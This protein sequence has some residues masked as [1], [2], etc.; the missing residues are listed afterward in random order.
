MKKTVKKS[1][2]NAI[3]HKIEVGI[4]SLNLKGCKIP[5]GKTIPAGTLVDLYDW[6]N[7]KQFSII[8]GALCYESEVSNVQKFHKGHLFAKGDKMY[9]TSSV[10]ILSIDESNE[11]YDIFTFSNVVTAFVDNMYWVRTNIS[12]PQ[13]SKFGFIGE[14]VTI[15]ENINELSLPICYGILDLYKLS[16]IYGIPYISPLIDPNESTVKVVPYY[17]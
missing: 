6:G 9:F 2:P 11:D 12:S 1:Y 17:T 5:K 3:I 13:D 4:A 7:G 8:K 14:Q 10:E 16:E 15:P